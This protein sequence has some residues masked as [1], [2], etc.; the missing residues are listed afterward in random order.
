MLTGGWPVLHCTAGAG[1]G[2]I[3]WGSADAAGGAAPGDAGCVPATSA[4]MRSGSSRPVAGA[5]RLAAGGG[6]SF[7]LMGRLVS[8]GPDDLSAPPVRDVGS[9]LRA[10]SFH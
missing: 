1:T 2:Q 9:P 3:R 10:E 4:A 6:A 7:S 5:V 8:A